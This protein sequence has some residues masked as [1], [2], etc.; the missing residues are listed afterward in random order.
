MQSK[1][2]EC[3]EGTVSG[4]TENGVYV[5]LENTVEGFISIQRLPVGRYEYSESKYMLQGVGRTFRIGDKINIRVVEV[6]IVTRHIDFEL[7]DFHREISEEDKSYNF[8][9]NV[10][11]NSK[12]KSHKGEY[13][14]RHGRHSGGHQKQNGF[15]RKNSDHSFKKFKKKHR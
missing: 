6:D 9:T 13:G 10:D 8:A 7:E 2:G 14:A 4:V 11:E 3:Y 12:A 1:I 5:E 15:S